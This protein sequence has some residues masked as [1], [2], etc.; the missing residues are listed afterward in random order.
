VLSAISTA[1]TR[2]RP[3]NADDTRSDAVFV[4]DPVAAIEVNVI[5][6]MHIGVQ[7]GYRFVSGMGLPGLRNRDVSGFTFG[8]IA[9]FGVF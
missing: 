3:D 4:L 6:F 8:A 1:Y 2:F 5:R 9:K 7:A